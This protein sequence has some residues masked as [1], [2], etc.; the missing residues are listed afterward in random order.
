MISPAGLVALEKNIQAPDLG[1]GTYR[2]HDAATVC[3]KGILT[4]GEDELFT[5]TIAVPLKAA[6]GFL[7]ERLGVTRQYAQMALVDAMTQAL[8]S[9]Q[10]GTTCIQ[11]RMRDI[12]EA[13]RQVQRTLEALP[14]KTRRG[15]TKV[16][17]NVEFS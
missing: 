12:D 9:E 4:R 7:L 6:M 13:M 11:E 8:A 16:D 10:S 5:P 14:K 3:I 15:K 1:A 2:I 17:V